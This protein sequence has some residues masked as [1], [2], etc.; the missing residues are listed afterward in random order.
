M[1]HDHALNAAAFDLWMDDYI[2]DPDA[3]Q[4]MTD[5]IRSHLAERDAGSTPSYGSVCAAA[6]DQYREKAAQEAS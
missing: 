5:S 4:E 3:F 6:L 2:K 1:N